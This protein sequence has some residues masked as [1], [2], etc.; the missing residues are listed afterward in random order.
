MSV[1]TFDTNHGDMIHDAQPDYY[2]KRLAT[3]SSDRS[4]SIFDISGE[5]PTRQAQ[6]LG[7]KG[8]VWQVAW[9]HPRFGGILASCSYDKRVIVWKE[10]QPNEWVQIYVFAGHETSVNSVAWA[11]QEYGLVLLAGSGDGYFSVHTYNAGQE[12]GV[13]RTKAHTG[14]VNSVAWAPVCDASAT[15][16]QIF[17]TGGC[18][19]NVHVWAKSEVGEWSNTKQ[20]S[21]AKAWVRG[22]AFAP[23]TG[24]PGLTLASCYDDGTV[25]VSKS[26]QPEQVG[27]DWESTS[28]SLNP[29]VNAW[30]VSW[31]L[32]GNML[33]VSS[34]EN[35]VTIYKEGPVNV[36][37]VVQN[38]SS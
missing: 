11:P 19:N 28:F 38:P 17:A 4:I 23:F 5:T 12:W 10:I 35:Q 27:A 24:L 34:G 30:S 32:T 3:C 18:D 33:A 37:T 16:T 36:W 22:V 14:G 26:V 31:S 1:S 25:T 8:P 2:G 15:T 29:K 9:A 13:V 6:L 20:L 7:H 21:Y